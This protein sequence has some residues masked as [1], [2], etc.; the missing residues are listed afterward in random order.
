MN[1][2][3]TSVLLQSEMRQGDSIDNGT[4]GFMCRCDSAVGGDKP[5]QIGL[6]LVKRFALNFCQQNASLGFLLGRALSR[7]IALVG[8]DTQKR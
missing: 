2:P 7:A 4:L 1:L 5:D 8:S 3:C 6:A